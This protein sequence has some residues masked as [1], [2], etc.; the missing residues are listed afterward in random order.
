MEKKWPI[1]QFSAKRLGHID[2]WL[3]PKNNFVYW[4][5]RQGG[6]LLFPVQ[7]QFC[8]DQNV[9][10]GLRCWRWVGLGWA[11]LA[12]PSRDAWSGSGGLPP[13][14]TQPSIWQSLHMTMSNIFLIL[15]PQGRGKRKRGQG[16]ES[17]VG[18]LKNT[19]F[20]TKKNRIMV[21]AGGR[22]FSKLQNHCIGLFYC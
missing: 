1:F 5:G 11:E 21:K 8:L 15:L 16:Q 18:N 7:L 3:G 6:L 17:I 4:V 13:I 22:G 10:C 12:R 14:D 20:E 19:P 9:C 2:Y